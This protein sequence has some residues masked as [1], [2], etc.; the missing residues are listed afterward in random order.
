MIKDFL[1]LVNNKG[2]N[3]DNSSPQLTH[4][5]NSLLMN[6]VDTPEKYLSNVDRKS[7]MRKVRKSSGKSSS[8]SF[9]SSINAI[10]NKFNRA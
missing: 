7:D 4:L 2:E 5:Q 3:N 9:S 6:I 8:T 1:K 10:H